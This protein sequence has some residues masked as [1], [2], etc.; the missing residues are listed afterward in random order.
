MD[1]KATGTSS[2]ELLPPY[3]R[4]N[5]RTVSLSMQDVLPTLLAIS[6][7]TFVVADGSS[8]TDDRVQKHD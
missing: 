3:V 1:N 2:L 5:Q 4:T 8:D 6:S 7:G